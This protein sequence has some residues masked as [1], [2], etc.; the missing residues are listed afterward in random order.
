MTER[1]PRSRVQL[2]VSLGRE[3]EPVPLAPDTPFHI[4]LL[5]DFRG[6]GREPG[7]MGAPRPVRVDRD[8]LDDVLARFAPALRIATG[9]GD[10]PGITVTF[11]EL[12]DFHPDRLLERVPAFAALWQ[13]RK[14]L[15]DPRTFAEAARA[16][17]GTD[18]GAAPPAS[19]TEPAPPAAR[20]VPGNL[21]EQILADVPGPAL[22]RLPAAPEDELATLVRRIVA[23]HLV[24]DQDPQQAALVAQVDALLVDGLRALLHHPEFQA[25]EALWRG[26]DFLTRRLETDGT[27][28]VYLVDVPRAML[29]RELATDEGT[30]RSSLWRLAVN[31]ID[32]APW[33]VLAGAYTFGA[34]EDDA[35]LL[36]RIARIARAA[37]TVFIAAADARLAGCAS[38][39]ATPDPDDWTLPPD[40]RFEAF[41]ATA[42]AAHVGLALPRFLLRL[43]YG[44]EGESCEAFDFEEFAGPPAHEHYLWGNP[45]IACALLL[46]QAFTQAGWALRPG[47]PAT[48]DKLPLYVAD[49]EG[50]AELQPC[51][52]IV[53][54]ERAAARIMERGLMPLASI[55]GTDAVQ[56]VRF[57]SV[58]SPL[59]ALAGR[60]RA[61]G[62]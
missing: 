15:A 41:R 6:A 5:G 8:D 48:I 3:P 53:M 42:D 18:V 37:G 55:R 32:G 52:E 60:W 46:G 21:L 40:P 31:G 28:R 57:Q 10:A 1:D 11:R 56:L 22:E 30:E 29:D 49:R 16:L 58:A 14:R 4:A 17:R 24:R 62:R 33:A 35:A 36:A 45:A 27:L 7:E 51:A 44:E 2:D 38:L 19:A 26:V 47:L 34:G 25:L 13:L 20:P 61:G 23:P 43:P 54:T 50:E 9:P 39:A 12:D 59:A